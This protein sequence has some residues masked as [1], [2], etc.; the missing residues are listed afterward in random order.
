MKINGIEIR[1]EI[2]TKRFLTELR[3]EPTDTLKQMVEAAC[4]ELASEFMVADQ[5]KFENPELMQELRETFKEVRELREQMK[6]LLAPVL[7]KTY[8]AAKKAEK[9]LEA[10]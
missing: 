7:R 5:L 2:S 8:R 6:A 9:A 1:V 4:D 10:A 3:L